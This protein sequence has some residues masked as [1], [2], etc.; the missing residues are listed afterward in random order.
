MW[1]AV[2]NHN[3]MCG[4]MYKVLFLDS[5]FK[6]L[7]TKYHFLHE[8]GPDFTYKNRYLKSIIRPTVSII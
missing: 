4:I 1:F 5:N 8:I 2:D 3:Y 7:L 6:W